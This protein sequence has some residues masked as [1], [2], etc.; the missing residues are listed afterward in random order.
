MAKHTLVV[1][2]DPI[3]LFLLKK[4]M[5]RTKFSEDV[6]YY[7]HS[8]SAIEALRQTYHKG[9]QYIILLDI[10]MPEMN[11]WEFLEE[12]SSF[13]SVDNT[14]VFIITSSTNEDD[15]EKAAKDP[16][17]RELIHKP[18]LVSHLSHVKNIVPG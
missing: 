14:Y 9:G 11:G 8:L 4:L 7:E 2:D 1:D 17:V 6:E 15:A 16:F 18:I 3:V 13:A 10:N 5:Q 12:L